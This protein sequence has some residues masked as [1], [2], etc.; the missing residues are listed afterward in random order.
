MMLLNS[1]AMPPASVPIVAIRSRCSSVAP[2]RAASAS[3][4]SR[5][6]ISW[7]AVRWCRRASGACVPADGSAPA[8][9]GSSCA[10]AAGC[11]RRR[12]RRAWRLPATAPSDARS[13][14]TAT[15]RPQRKRHTNARTRRVRGASRAADALECRTLIEARG[16]STTERSARLTVWRCSRPDR[17]IAEIEIIGRRPV[18]WH[19]GQRLVYLPR[20]RP[21]DPR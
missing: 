12:P 21:T 13:P 11:E 16:R 3:E 7:P 2:A 6:R 18:W 8:L 1:W 19:R 9:R 20:R 15:W 4:A 17:L 5:S 14:P 10:S